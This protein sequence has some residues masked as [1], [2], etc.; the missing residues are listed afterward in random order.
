MDNM[1]FEND[2]VNLPRSGMLFTSLVLE[3]YK[4]RSQ[5]LTNKQLLPQYHGSFFLACGDLL[6]IKYFQRSIDK[7]TDRALKRF[8]RATCHV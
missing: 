4:K 7:L 3:R 8:N 6:S 2:G 5:T 1:D